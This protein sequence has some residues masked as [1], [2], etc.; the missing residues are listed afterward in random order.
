MFQAAGFRS[1]TKDVRI[2]FHVTRCGIFGWPSDT[3]AGFSSKYFSFR[4]SVSF[5]CCY[6]FKWHC[7][8]FFSSTSVFTCRYHST[9]A[10]YSNGTIAGFFPVLQFSPVSIILLLLHIQMT[11][12]QV[13]LSVLQFSPVSIILLLLHIQ[14]ALLQVFLAV[15]RFSPVSIILLLLHIQCHYCRFFFRYFSFR[16][17][18]SFYCCYIFMPT[19]VTDVI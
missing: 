4:L 3:G 11:L 18:V 16:L 2:Q 7:C 8:R 14:M 15:L 13:F 6:I 12:L 9:V 5:Y 1:I 17:S 10:T 19:S